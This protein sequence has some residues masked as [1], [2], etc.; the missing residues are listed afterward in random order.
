MISLTWQRI[1]SSRSRLILSVLAI[2]IGTSFLTAAL[3]VAASTRAAL[4]DAFDQVYAGTDLIVQGRPGLGEASR[5]LGPI[6]PVAALDEIRGVPGVAVAEGRRRDLA[7]VSAA[8]TDAVPGLTAVAMDV[9]ADPDAAA[10]EQRSGRLPAAPHEVA[11]DAATTD[12]LGLTLED[13][14]VIL[15]PAIQYE[16]RLV[17]TVGFGSLDGLAGGGRVLLDAGSAADLLGPTGFA[18]I[19]VIAESDSQL[20]GLGASIAAVLPDVQVLTARDA[21]ARDAAAVAAET[22][23]V[24]RILL[25]VAGLALF[26]GGFLVANTFRIIARQRTRELALLRSVGAS[27][28]QITG[29][30]LLEAAIMGALGGLI[31]VA[32]GAGVGAVLVA[33]T[34]TL[35]PGLPPT[36]PRFTLGTLAIGPAVSVVLTLL[37]ALGSARHASAVPPVAA[38]RASAV[39]ADR[40]RR[41]PAVLGILLIALG[42]GL[43]VVG[44]G[45][46]LMITAGGAVVAL[47][48]VGLVFPVVSGAVLSI[49][50]RPLER[51]GVTAAIAR[52]QSLAEPRRTGSTAAALAVSLALFAFLAT[53][54]ASLGA[55]SPTQ[56][57]DRQPA[58]ITIRSELPWGLDGYLS[59]LADRAEALDAVAIA[60]DVAYGDLQVETGDGAPVAA[61]F[62]AAD[63]AGLGE[64][65]DVIDR[66]GAVE[67]LAATEIGIRD[68]FANAYG[69]QLGDTIAITLP[70]AAVMQLTIGAVF[71]GAIQTNWIVPAD[72]A[73]GH[74]GN[75]GR[76]VF[77]RLVDGADVAAADAALE[78]LG[79]EYPPVEVLTHEE[80]ATQQV[81]AE[82]ASLG[83]LTALLSLTVLI[84]VLGIVNTLALGVVERHR[85]LGLLRAVGA[86]RSQVRAIVR[87]E[88][89]LVALL[90]GSLGL[91]VGVGTAWLATYAFTEFPLPFILPAPRLALALVVTIV[92]GVLAAI[93]PGARAARVD[94]LR[95]IARV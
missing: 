61:A 11:L 92:L 57:A 81:E 2:V 68:H 43:V 79:A 91:V 24:S 72:A 71:S 49:L 55:A 44:G 76:Q 31:G 67:G 14:L 78:E 6:L 9:P 62:Y 60:R 29:T 63:P 90:G 51:L 21:A 37:A 12:S 5:S 94:V 88:A 69:W 75:A 23:I 93:V 64:L 50:S 8:T 20:E 53:F 52:G 38:L 66:A 27:R 36:A 82:E 35:V 89:V 18:E 16:A 48:G 70:D 7:Q 42:T 95:S 85:E 3:V 74:L 39:A 46:G 86:T 54:A 10:I 33:G 47:L 83:I 17:G 77:V 41:L 4:N 58:E 13:E 56:V 87:W 28:R 22:A 40:P 25:A 73:A 1:R 59:D 30:V 45:S 19:A 84:G 34:G 65:L 32:L 15:L 26:V 80:L